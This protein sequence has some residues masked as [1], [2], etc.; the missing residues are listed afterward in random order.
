[1]T[2]K[3]LFQNDFLLF[4]WAPK[5]HLDICGE[6]LT[7]LSLAVS[8]PFTY[9]CIYLYVVVVI[10]F[11]IHYDCIVLIPLVHMCSHRDGHR[12]L[13]KIVLL[14]LLDNEPGDVGA[15]DASCRVR[16]HVSIGDCRERF[17]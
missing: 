3:P 9:T 5:I 13:D 1:M 11:I 16:N 17:I 15:A 4:G 7:L 6:Q 8:L 10:L 14:C 2:E 12:T